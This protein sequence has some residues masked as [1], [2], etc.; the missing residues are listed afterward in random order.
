M[1]GSTEEHAQGLCPP[2]WRIPSHDDWKKL[3]GFVDSQYDIG[4]PIWDNLG[5]NGYDVGSAL[6][7]NS[8]LWN[9]GILKENS[10]FE[11]YEAF[12]G[13]PG[14]Y[15]YIDGNFAFIN[16]H[17][18]WWSSTNIATNANYYVVSNQFTNS[19]IGSIGKPRAYYVR[20]IK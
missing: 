13:I 3:Y 19:L 7:Y 14:G 6:A 1:N 10:S 4:D 11:D 15:R 16:T 12:K 9:D 20:C 5:Y 2:G 18:C 8:I 17:A